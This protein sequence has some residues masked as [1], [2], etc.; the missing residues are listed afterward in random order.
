MSLW[1]IWRVEC[2]ENCNGTKICSHEGLCMA[3]FR[4]WEVEEAALGY[5]KVK[6][7]NSWVIFGFVDI[8]F[9]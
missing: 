7:S 4:S 8:V 5:S 6:K 1:L 3:D 2:S 9:I